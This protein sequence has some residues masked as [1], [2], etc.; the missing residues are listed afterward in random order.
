MNRY[1]WITWV[2]ELLVDRDV[3]A[4]AKR[5][6]IA[7]ETAVM[8]GTEKRKIVENILLPGV[9]NGGVYL[10]RALIELWLGQIRGQGRD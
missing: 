10:V 7:L 6:V 8:S 2:C 3:R 1:D 5:E 9:I 4:A